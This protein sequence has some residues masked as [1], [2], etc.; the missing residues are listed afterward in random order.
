[1]FKGFKNIGETIKK[2]TSIITAIEMFG[3]LIVGVV[4]MFS[5]D[6]GI[7]LGL[8]IIVIGPLVSYVN[9]L[10]MTGFG[11]LINRIISIDKKVSEILNKSN[12]NNSTPDF[13]YAKTTPDNNKTF[14]NE[15]K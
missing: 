1:M 15:E 14:N 10:V 9:G 6:D 3:S 5:S 2:F 4:V 13:C 12:P 7:L 11:E 8:L